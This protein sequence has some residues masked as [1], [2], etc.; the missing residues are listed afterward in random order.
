MS[1]SG[2]WL[3][4]VTALLL[5]CS[6]VTAGTGSVAFA[7]KG[8]HGG[9][10]GS[11]SGGGASALILYDTTNTWGYLGELYATG[12]ANLA[13]HF[14]SYHAEPVVDYTAG[15]LSSYTAT[16][17]LGSTYDEPIPSAFLADV[18]ATS[19]PVIWI[20]YNIWELA[21][22]AG[23]FYTRYGWTP[24]V[25]DP[26]TVTSVVY[27]GVTL[28][29][30][31]DNGTYSVMNYASLDPSRVTVLATAV[32]SDGSTFPWA[33]RS[34][35][36]TYIGD[37]PFPYTDEEDR[38]LAFEDLLFDALAPST[39]TRHRAMVRLEDIDPTADP[40]Q[41]EQDADWLYSQHIPFGFNIIPKYVDPTG[42]YNNGVP[43]TVTL[44]QSPGVVNAIKYMEARGGVLVD[45]GY[46]HQYSDVYNPFTG[47]TGDDYEFYRVTQNSD[48]T[49]DFVGPVAED[50]TT[51][52]SDRV[53]SALSLFKQTKVGTPQIFVVPHYAASVP[54]YAVFQSS[55]PERWDRGM[56]YGGVLSGGTP[57]YAH[58]FGQFF[59]Y[60][61]HDVYGSKVLPE[62]CGDISPTPWEIWPAR[63][64]SDIIT[65]AQD[66]LVVRD[67]FAV[68]TFHPYLDISYL[69]QTV[70]GL[71]AAGYSF[72]S[73]ASL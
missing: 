32:R 68:F 58:L 11:T 38:L 7:G 67:G 48:E 25:L 24:G 52:A 10:G 22:Y 47:V 2:R 29:R 15:Q 1:R 4:R 41:L 42:Y 34:G 6:A 49:L 64:P 45:E 16:I 72:V 46:T 54:D 35:N 37:N 43:Q 61:V 53:N 28:A 51:W 12:I 3:V 62:N 69:Q 73:P 70:Q 30:S 50:S 9:G 26:G 66:N 18:L 39:P 20:Y 17:Y 8:S 40:T 13:S 65:C 56:Y 14:G 60:V 21:T 5:A 44:K 71:Q 23:D 36:L 19:K 33:V 63:L 55:Y 31:A 27:K 59:P 57:D